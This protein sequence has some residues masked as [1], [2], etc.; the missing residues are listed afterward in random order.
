MTCKEAEAIC[1][2]VKKHC[3]EVAVAETNFSVFG[4]GPGDAEALKTDAYCSSCVICLGAALL[5]SDCRAYGVCPYGVI[6]ADGLGAAY[7]LFAINALGKADVFAFF[8]AVD[9]VF[10]EYA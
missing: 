10:F 3:A 9:A 2:V 5:Y 8:N 6:E 4:N 1:I 7:Y